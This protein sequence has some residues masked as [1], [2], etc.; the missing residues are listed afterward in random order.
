MQCKSLWIKA[1]AKCI[2]VNVNVIIFHNIT[3]LTVFWT[4]KCRLG[5]PKAPF[6]LQAILGDKATRSHSFQWRAGDFRRH[7]RQRPLAT[8]WGVSSDATKFRILQL[9]ANEE[10]LSGATANRKEDGWA[11][12]IV[13]LSAVDKHTRWEKNRLCFSFIFVCMYGLNSYLY[14]I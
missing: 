1:S 6:T 5:R 8:G 13:L 3:I 9:Y 2:N 4:N 14:Y 7:E 11:H 10:R 12:V